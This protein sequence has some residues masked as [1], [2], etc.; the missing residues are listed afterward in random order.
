LHFDTHR[1]SEITLVT[2]VDEYE[3]RLL[4]FALRLVGDQDR[5]KDLV[6]ETFMA[7]LIHIWQLQNLNPYQ[8]RS[9]LY[10]V[11][12][13]KFI[14]QLR[15]IQR[16]QNLMQRLVDITEEEPNPI[17]NLALSTLLDRIPEIYRKVLHKRFLLEMTSEEIGKE[18]DLPAATVRSRIHLGIQWLRKHQKWIE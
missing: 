8:I 5:A 14:D 17:N 6:Q 11:L 18:L 13:N 10:K 7:A 9:W 4:Q 2:L 12:K 3:K 15:V 1:S 16:E